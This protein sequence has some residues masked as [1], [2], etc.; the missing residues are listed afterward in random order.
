MATINTGDSALG[1]YCPK[2]PVTWHTHARTHAHTYTHTHIYISFINPSGR[3]QQH[4]FYFSICLCQQHLLYWGEAPPGLAAPYQTISSFDIGD[5]DDQRLQLSWSLFTQL[6]SSLR[7][8][9]QYHRSLAYR[10]W[11]RDSKC[12]TNISTSALLILPN[13][14]HS[15]CMMHWG[16]CLHVFGWLQNWWMG[17]MTSL[18]SDQRQ[19]AVRN[20]TQ[21]KSKS[22]T[23]PRELVGFIILSPF[24][25]WFRLSNELITLSQS[26]DDITWPYSDLSCSSIIALRT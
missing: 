12:L 3:G 2:H 21:T 5:S 4:G 22:G 23:T 19:N 13:Y 8:T 24:W 17:A 20:I 9:C 1:V 10:I 18:V 11:S 15:R 14:T 7:C 16:S 26:L 6:S 25:F